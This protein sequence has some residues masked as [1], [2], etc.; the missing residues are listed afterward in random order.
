MPKNIFPYAAFLVLVAIA[1]APVSGQSCTEVAVLAQAGTHCTSDADCVDPVRPMCNLGTN[2]C[3]SIRM[4]CLSDTDCINPAEPMC[5]TA[6]GSCS[7]TP[8][9]PPEEDD[10][11]TICHKGKKT[12]S[13]GASAVP[14]HLAHGDSLGA[15]P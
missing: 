2:R 8:S 11:V 4:G 12:L 7:P 14:A 10:K 5:D 15:C 9:D 3:E 6:T 13:V 1:M